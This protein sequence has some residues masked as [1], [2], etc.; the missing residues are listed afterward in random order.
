MLDTYTLKFSPV[1]KS[2]KLRKCTVFSCSKGTLEICFKHFSFNR[3][4]FNN[5][6]TITHCQ[7]SILQNGYSTML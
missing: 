6:D 3:L 2:N 7:P 1:V 4:I 5:S